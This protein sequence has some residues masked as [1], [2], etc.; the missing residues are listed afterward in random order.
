MIDDRVLAAERFEHKIQ[1]YADFYDA[2]YECRGI[3]C[4]LDAAQNNCVVSLKASLFSVE[5]SSYVG[6]I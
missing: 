2:H 3:F 6:F 5:V 4:F 1:T